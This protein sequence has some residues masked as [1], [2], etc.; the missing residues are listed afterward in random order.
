[1]AAKRRPSTTWPFCAGQERRGQK[2][3]RIRSVWPL[4]GAKEGKK[5]QCQMPIDAE[6]PG[7]IGGKMGCWALP[8]GQPATTHFCVGYGTPQCH[9]FVLC[10]GGGNGVNN[11]LADVCLCEMCS[12]VYWEFIKKF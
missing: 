1:M 5:C 9:C 4:C 7:A 3:A 6:M 8:W 2:G 10:I 11:T 12:G